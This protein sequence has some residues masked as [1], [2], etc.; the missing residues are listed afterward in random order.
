MP[1]KKQLITVLQ[2]KKKNHQIVWCEIKIEP[3]IIVLFIF[4]FLSLNWAWCC[5]QVHV[6]RF[7]VGDAGHQSAPISQW[8]LAQK[9]M[10]TFFYP[11][12]KGLSVDC[13]SEQPFNEQREPGWITEDEPRCSEQVQWMSSAVTQYSKYSS[14]RDIS[15][16]LHLFSFQM[17]FNALNPSSLCCCLSHN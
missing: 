2:L 8:V 5:V 3:S 17:I 1:K 7:L 13:F 6:C 14:H 15:C 12:Y 16:F 4:H 9:M 10:L 11:A